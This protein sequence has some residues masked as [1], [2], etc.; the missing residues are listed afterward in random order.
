MTLD[1]DLHSIMYGLLGMIF[2]SWFVFRKKHRFTID[3]RF[4]RIKLS[5]NEGLPIRNYIAI[6]DMNDSLSTWFRFLYSDRHVAVRYLRCFQDNISRNYIIFPE[7]FL[8][9]NGLQYRLS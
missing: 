6:Y 1:V 8:R 9:L 7:S 5:L 3:V 4:R 2:V